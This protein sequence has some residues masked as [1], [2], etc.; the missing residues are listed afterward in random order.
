[1][2]WRDTTDAS[3]TRPDAPKETSMRSLVTYAATALAVFG[4]S[5]PGYG[6]RAAS[7]QPMSLSQC[8]WQ[9]L[10]QFSN[11][12]PRALATTPDGGL[13]LAADDLSDPAHTTLVT[14][15]WDGPGASWQVVDRYLPEGSTATGARALHVDAEG[16]ALVLAWE[17]GGSDTQLLLRRSFGAGDAGTWESGETRWEAQRGGGLAST[18]DGRLFVAYGFRDPRA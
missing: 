12:V 6:Q 17:Q 4:L 8:E 5:A 2:R 3:P 9:P 18:P 7:V 10:A 13:L 11:T 14:L 15:R 1:R 16:N